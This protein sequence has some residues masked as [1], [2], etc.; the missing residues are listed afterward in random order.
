MTGLP[1][2]PRRRPATLLGALRRTRVLPGTRPRLGLGI[3]VALLAVVTATFAVYLLK[4]VAPVVSLSVVYLPAVLLVSTYWGV[5]LGLATAIGSAASFNFFHLPPT[6]R[7]T[8]ADGRNW[9]ALA[10]FVVVALTTSAVA[11]LARARTLE[12]ERRRAEADLAAA[13]ARELLVG[14]DTQ[15]ALESAARRLSEALGLRWRDVDL[16]RC[17][18]ELQATLDRVCQFA[19]ANVSRVG[20]SEFPYY[21]GR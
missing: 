10:A 9:V 7:F 20:T 8:I 12:A 13:L 17:T 2:S 19:E 14:D 4:Q 3:A 15:R 6:G 1:A 18:A 16:E 11:E 5:A 21:K